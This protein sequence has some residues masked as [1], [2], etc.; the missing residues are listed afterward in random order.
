MDGIALAIELAAARVKVLPPRQLAQKLDER[1]R[2]L[3][4]GSRTALPR[5]QT[6]RA[7]IDWSYDLLSGHEQK[8]FRRV[9]IFVGGWTLEA[10]EAVVNDET[11]DAL[12]IIDLISSLVEKSLVVAGAEEILR[13][14]LLESTRAFALEKLEQSGEHDALARRHAQWA[15]DLAERAKDASE[16]EPWTQWLAE[17]MAEF[18]MRA[19]RLNGRFH[20]MR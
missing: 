5:Q 12:D 6:M 11:L 4:G 20:T 7:L 13:Y 17:Y 1:F 9:S 10:A 2:V 16:T 14:R 18:E 3:T 8:L 19:P 15:S